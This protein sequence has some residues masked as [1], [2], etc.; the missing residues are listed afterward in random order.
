MLNNQWIYK[1]YDRADYPACCRMLGN[2]KEKNLFCEK[3]KKKLKQP[4]K[5]SC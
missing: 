5:S 1:K 4:E 2:K 3:F